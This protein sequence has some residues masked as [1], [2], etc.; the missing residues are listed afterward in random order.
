[1]D[2]RWFSTFWGIAG[3]VGLYFWIR[4]SFYKEVAIIAALFLCIN[5]FWLYYCREM[6]NFS[7]LL[8]LKMK[9]LVNNLAGQ[10]LSNRLSCYHLLEGE[11]WNISS[12]ACMLHRNC[13]DIPITVQV[14]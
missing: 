5:P 1:M 13:T 4:R 9:T 3:L 6:R 11:V 12:F 10:I 2:L 8:S 14:E 7:G